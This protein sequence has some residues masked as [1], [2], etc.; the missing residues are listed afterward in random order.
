MSEASRTQWST[1]CFRR[2]K[3][4]EDFNSFAMAVELFT[5]LRNTRIARGRLLACL[6]P[7]GTEVYHSSGH[8]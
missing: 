5:P 8:L 7:N 1:I 3:A 2:N 6:V 4:Q